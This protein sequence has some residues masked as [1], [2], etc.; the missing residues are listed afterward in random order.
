MSDYSVVEI[1]TTGVNPGTE[2]VLEISAL[3]VRNN[4]AVAVYSTRIKPAGVCVGEMYNTISKLDR[5]VN[6]LQDFIGNDVVLVYSRKGDSEGR[7]REQTFMNACVDVRDVVRRVLPD[8]QN[9]MLETVCAHYCINTDGER[10]GLR[11]CYL[12]KACYEMLHAEFGENM[13]GDS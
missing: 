1:Q 3:K 13:F 2:D 5:A 6:D 11:N 4:D 8:L 9:D 7:L 10:R 12:V